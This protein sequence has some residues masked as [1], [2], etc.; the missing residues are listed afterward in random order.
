MDNQTK[1]QSSKE[2]IPLDGTSIPLYDR[3]FSLALTSAGGSSTLDG[4]VYHCLFWK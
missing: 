1:I 4:Y 2:F 3:G